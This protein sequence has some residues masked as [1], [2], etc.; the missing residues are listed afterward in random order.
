MLLGGIILI[1]GAYILSYT[2]DRTVKFDAKDIHI[3]VGWFLVVPIFYGGLVAISRWYM[4]TVCI[5]I[6]GDNFPLESDKYWLI[7]IGPFWIP[8]SIAY[9]FGKW[10]SEVITKTRQFCGEES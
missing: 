1:I 4:Y 6:F 9:L 8:F 7:A 3:H 2:F 10:N 5:P